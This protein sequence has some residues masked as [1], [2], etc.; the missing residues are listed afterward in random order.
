MH[1]SLSIACDKKKETYAK[2]GDLEVI[3]DNSEAGG[4]LAETDAKAGQ[5]S[6]ETELS[7]PGSVDV[8]ERDDLR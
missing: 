2:V 8:G 6:S 7:C 3:K 1:G 4:A 5:V